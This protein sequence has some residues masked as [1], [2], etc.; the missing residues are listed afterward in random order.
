MNFS[1]ELAV[2]VQELRLAQMSPQEV[3]TVKWAILD[4]LGCV[5]AGVGEA[6]DRAL[7][8]RIAFC[9]G[10]EASVIGRPQKTTTWL[11]A[12]MNGTLGHSLD[13][14]DTAGFG[15]ASV[16]IVPAL[17]ATGER[18]D[19]DGRLLLEAYMAAYEIGFALNTLTRRGE[20]Q[21][22]GMHATGI[23][24]PITS[25]TA[26]AKIMGLDT[27]AT[28]R[29]WGVAVSQAA[30][31]TGNFGTHT[32]PLHAGLA[33]QSGVLAAELASTGFTANRNALEAPLG[34]MY[35][36]V[37]PTY[38]EAIDFT[39]ALEVLGK[40]HIAT[41]LAFK[42]YPCGF[43]AQGA[44]ETALKLRAEFQ[45]D[46]QRIESV[47]IR[48]PVLESF[49]RV[50]PT[51][52][53]AGKFSYQFTVASALLDGR[54]TKWTFS[55]ASSNR[56]ELSALTQRFSAEVDPDSGPHGVLVVRAGGKEY[57][58][59]VEPAPGHVRNP[60]SPESLRE[61]FLLNAEPVLGETR[62]REVAERVLDLEHQDDLT[63]LMDVLC[64]RR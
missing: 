33:S 47:Q 51:G 39:R 36:V 52:D 21:H 45:L 46:V 38:Y 40:G 62:S 48:V 19:V 17:L 30:G 37:A 34:F 64:L 59:A 60:M 27:D 12:F 49:F 28:R 32:K 42:K 22:H 1:Q 5:L 56:P 2:Y 55:D 3:R 43:I 20:D 35:S 44:I 58:R 8:G 57:S 53:V 9:P 6:P 23:F 31:V 4:Y 11:A 7:W 61:K 41:T 10:V 54:V 13:Y 63:P 25:A 15:H 14:D 26:A 16:I 29:A 24:G 18:L 50:A